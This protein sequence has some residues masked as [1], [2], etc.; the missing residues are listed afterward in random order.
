MTEG[1]VKC[2]DL[3]DLLQYM[4]EGVFRYKCPLRQECLKTINDMID[5]CI[6]VTEFKTGRWEKSEYKGYMRCSECH[7]CYVSERWVTDKKWHFCP[8]CGARLIK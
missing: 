7:D 2:K 1:Y 5:R 8:T 6:H 4:S 3:R